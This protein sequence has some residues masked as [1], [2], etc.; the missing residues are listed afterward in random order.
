MKCQ[1][2]H[3]KDSEAAKMERLRINANEDSHVLHECLTCYACQEYC[4]NGNNPFYFLVERQ[5]D[6]GILPAPRPIVTEQLRMMDFKNRIQ[7]KNVTAPIVNMCAFPMLT[8]CIRGS[9]FQGVSTFV[10]TDIFCNI[11]WLHF[12]KNSVIRERLPHAIENIMK[13]FLANVETKEMICFHDECYGT[14]TS[15]AKAFD[16]DVPFQPIHLFDY[17]NKR[18]D[19]LSEQIKP[20]NEI[21]A[22]QRPCSNRLIPQTDDILDQIFNKIGA[23]RVQRKYD[24]ENALCCGGVVRAHQR[25]D[26]ADDLMQRNIDDMKAIGAKYCVFNCPFCMA[27][28]GQDVAENGIMPILVSDLV[29]TALGE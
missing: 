1:Y 28:L 25:D 21:I 18:L 6:M 7:H 14:Y 15:V 2:I 29:Q 5:E 19:D 9:L 8:G 13:F 11:M 16:I 4:P 17:M 3:F 22:Y 10:G 24:R 26:L 27:T 23:N 20:I 12:A